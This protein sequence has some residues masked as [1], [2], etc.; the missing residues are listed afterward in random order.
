MTLLLITPFFTLFSAFRRAAAFAAL[1][2]GFALTPPPHSF[3]PRCRQILL[4]I[5][6][7]YAT[8]PSIATPI[9]QLPLPPFRAISAVCRFRF[10]ERHYFQLFCRLLPL[11]AL[12]I[13]T[14][15]PY[16]G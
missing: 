15:P 13:L 9:R 8:L 7:D 6:I 3:P 16:T 12:T 14:L 5:S 10:F 11:T 4:N 1:A 2:L